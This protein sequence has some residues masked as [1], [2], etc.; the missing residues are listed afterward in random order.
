MRNSFQRLSLKEDSSEVRPL[1]TAEVPRDRKECY[2]LWLG[3]PSKQFPD[4]ILSGC[5]S[6]VIQNDPSASP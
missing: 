3:Q 1:I 4:N 2:R 6:Y 5:T